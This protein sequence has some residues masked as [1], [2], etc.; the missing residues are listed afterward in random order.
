VF[1]GSGF[2]VTD[3]RKPALSGAEGSSPSGESDAKPGAAPET[4]ADTT[5]ADT[6]SETPS[7][8]TSSSTKD[9]EPAAAG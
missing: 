3:S 5:K 6:K 1:K 4:K 9:A 7:A 2:Y 8:G